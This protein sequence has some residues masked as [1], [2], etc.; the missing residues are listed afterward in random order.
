[1]IKVNLKGGA[2]SGSDIYLAGMCRPAVYTLP[3]KAT[4]QDVRRADNCYADPDTVESAIERN[5]ACSLGTYGCHAGHGDW[6]IGPAEQIWKAHRRY[7]SGSA[8]FLVAQA[9]LK[10]RAGR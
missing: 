2:Y 9:A 1:M 6:E 3:R 10:A 8:R 4:V 7:P 5:F